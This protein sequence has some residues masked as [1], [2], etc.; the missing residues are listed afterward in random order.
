MNKPKLS[1]IVLTIAFIAA[2]LAAVNFALGRNTE[3]AR[4]VWVEGQLEKLTVAKEALEQEKEELTKTKETLEGQLKDAS[5]QA[6]DLA[7]QIA[8][9]KRARESLTTEMSKIRKESADAAQRLEK[10]RAAL[11]EELAKA[12]QSYQTLSNE[13]TTLRQAK[14]ALEKRVKEMLAVQ[15]N[16]AERIVVKPAPGAAAPKLADLPSAKM[17][18]GKVLV[19]N[20]E[21]NFIVV[22]LGSKDGVKSGTQFNVL[23]AN[24]S[25][26]KAQVER[27]YDNMAAATLLVEEQKG[28]IKEGDLVRLAS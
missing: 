14:E 22:N 18:E 2:A 25:I 27:L 17:L 5:T 16:E 6:K 4:R 1:T 23:R 21:F 11:N 10:E 19:V 26:G 28:Q 8:A 9:E 15:A 7:E 13:L 20:R 12:K 3:R 24:K